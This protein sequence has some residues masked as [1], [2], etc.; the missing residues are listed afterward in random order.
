MGY[1]KTAVAHRVC[2][3]EA[4]VTMIIQLTELMTLCAQAHCL[5]GY[6][7]SRVRIY[8]RNPCLLARL[9]ALKSQQ[10]EEIAFIVNWSTA[11]SVVDC[12][13]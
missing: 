5:Q 8:S 6:L 10:N 3:C 7:I 1:G 4:Y 9:L 11:I 13:L 12:C 2:A